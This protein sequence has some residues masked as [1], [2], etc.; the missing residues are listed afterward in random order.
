MHLTDCAMAVQDLLPAHKLALWAFADSA[1]HHTR[2]GLPGIEGVMRA[3]TCSRARAFELIADLVTQGY[4][5]KH[6]GGHRGRRAEYIVF[7]QGCCPEHQPITGDTADPGAEPRVGPEGRGVKTT[8][9]PSVVGTAGDTDS[10][11]LG[12]VERLS[13]SAAQAGFPLSSDQLD[14]LRGLTSPDQKGP[15]HRTQTPNKGSGT[16]DSSRCNGSGTPDPNAAEPPERVRRT[17]PFTE[18]GSR[19]GPAHRTPSLTTTTTPPSPRA[20]GAGGDGQTGHGPQPVVRPAQPSQHRGQHANCRACGTTSRQHAA[21]AARDNADRTRAEARDRH[22]A[23]QA[24]T[25]AA[26]VPST[27]PSVQAHLKAA[28]A[29]IGGTR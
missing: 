6:R 25:A 26:A 24:A 11:T 20:S 12:L 19:K 27:T 28:R 22:A 2:I 1:D 18:K 3:A 5:L 23:E 8:T 10:G 17:G 16:P 15:A 13:A 21:A 29:A 14:V 7:P 9:D 4:L